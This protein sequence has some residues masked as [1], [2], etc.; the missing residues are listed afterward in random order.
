MKTCYVIETKTGN[1]YVGVTSNLENRL[2]YHQTTPK[3]KW[4]EGWVSKHGGFGRLVKSTKVDDKKAYQM[5]LDTVREF[6]RIYPDKLIGGDGA[7]YR[8]Q[9][10][11]KKI[12]GE[13]VI[14]STRLSRNVV[15][16]LTQLCRH[17]GF[18]IWT[19]VERAIKHEIEYIQNKIDKKEP[20]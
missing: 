13:R 8:N 2:W 9:E 17:Q 18:F 19:F 6:K 11:L 10:D 3:H 12:Y 5:E 1:F 15:S 4:A 7:R 16:K 20:L 14:F